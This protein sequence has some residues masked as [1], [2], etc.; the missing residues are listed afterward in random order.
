MSER[1]L[2][3]SIEAHLKMICNEVGNRHVGSAG[4]R[5]ATDYAERILRSHGFETQTKPFDCIDWEHGDVRLEAG[6]EHWPA[7]VGPYSLPYD[8]EAELVAVS[9]ID[10]LAAAEI[11]GKIVLLHGDIAREQVMPKNFVFY[12]PEHHKEIVRLLE[13]GGPA[14]LICATGKNPGAAGSPYPFPLFE[15]GDFNIP[16]VTM[17]DVD[18]ER[19]LTQAGTAI[20]LVFASRRIPS[21]GTNVV[22]RAG[23]SGGAKI[24]LCAHIDAKKNTPGA[25]DNGTGVA[26]LLGLGELLREHPVRRAIEIVLFNGEDYYAAPGQMQYLGDLGERMSEI[27]LVVNLDGAGHRGSPLAYSFYECPDSI[28]AAA[29]DAFSQDPVFTEGVPWVQ[30][31]HSMF[32]MAGRP[33]IALTSGDF[34]WLCREITH[35]PKDATDLVDVQTLAKAAIAL[36]DLLHGL[37]AGGG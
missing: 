16:S 24:L 32:V 27:D 23:E 18:G 6:G 14:A 33:A 29:V 37:E 35:T 22:A 13:A 10:E 30:G 15:D 12:N 8:G 31:D 2:T 19:L 5:E 21:T 28:R 26:V 4:N 20:R 25:L 3:R 36:R 7:T 11:E 1:A 9:S 34:E 17:K